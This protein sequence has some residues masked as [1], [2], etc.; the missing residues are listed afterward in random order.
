MNKIKALKE[1]AEV[2][3][4]Y[5]C[6]IY[7]FCYYLGLTNVKEDISNKD[8]EVLLSKCEELRGEYGYSSIAAV[9]GATYPKQLQELRELMQLFYQV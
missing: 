4:K 6:N 1:L 8:L 5:D 3:G 2:F 7:D 9:V